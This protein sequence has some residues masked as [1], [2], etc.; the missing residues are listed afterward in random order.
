MSS[1]FGRRAAIAGV[2]VATFAVVAP[3]APAAAHHVGDV[4]CS[5]FTYQEDAQEW[6]NAH[7]GDPDRLDGTDND[8]LACE[9]LPRR[10]AP[11]SDPCAAS[12]WVEGAIRTRYISLGGPCG[13]LGNPLT[14]ELPT[15][16]KPGR[17]N[18]FQGGSIYWSSATGAWEVHGGIR[19]AWGRLG[20]ENS[21]LGFPITNERRTPSK[22]GAY[23]HFQSGSIYWS[24]ATGA[25]EVRG[26]IRNKWAALG[27]EN[28]PLGFPTTDER[29]T[30][31]KPGAYNHFQS[32]S[33]YWSSA[34]GAHEVRGGIRN[35]W[36]ELGWE[37]GS[38]GFPVSDEYAI[39]GGRRSDFQGGHITWSP[40]TGAVIHRPGS[41]L[42]DGNTTVRTVLDH[43]TVTP[44]D[45]GSAYDRALFAHWIDADGDGCDT[46]AEVLIQESQTAVGIEP[47]CHVATGQWFSYYD[48]ATWTLASDVDVDH[49][50]ALKEAWDSGAHSWTSD[51]RRAFANDL[52]YEWSLE[53][54]TDNVNMSK[55]DSDPAQWLPPATAAVCTYATRWVAVKY[56]WQLTIDTAEHDALANILI[57]SCG[58]TVIATPPQA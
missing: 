55:S 44:E 49:V 21:H 26:G 42:P 48:E 19:S 52:T 11:P 50:V 32:G 38:L 36:A 18:H 27:W 9:S 53:A 8:G 4:D 45:T 12:N 35:K 23:N 28:G 22:P 7:P 33:I 40:Q 13:F 41:D 47:P 31:S 37:N 25:H 57:G 2:I 6:M 29:R 10:P 56:R 3:M 5:D 14:R 43:L 20:W 30:P 39:P 51:R 46:R 24:S 1:W 54:V 16:S 58:S 17:Y 34:T 15:P